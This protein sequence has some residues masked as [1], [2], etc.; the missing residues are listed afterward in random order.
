VS[1]IK[2][3][4]AS[5]L[6]RLRHGARDLPPLA[7]ANLEAADHLAGGRPARGYSY[8]VVD[9]ETTG[10]DTASDR[11]V[12]VGAVRVA[13]GRVRLGD[14][15]VE[16]VNPGRGIPAEA[17]KIHGI[18]PDQV[19]GARDAAAV[20]QDFLAW[21]GADILV[22]HY[23]EFDLH[24]INLTMRRLYGFPLQNLVLDVV[25]MCRGVVLP[26]DPYGLDRHRASCAL[27]SLAQRF[28]LSGAERHT[29]AGDALVTAMIFQRLL[30]RLES[31]G[32]GRLADLARVAAL[33]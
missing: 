17:V 21:L 4:L 24:F 26:S 15:F 14:S 13:G 30:A 25:R 20:F 5:R 31:R 23:A 7:K 12:A 2:R 11:V 19:A 22:A 29:A 33:D 9:L 8:A 1:L 16:L 6:A 28:G 18:K 3:K 32:P 27:E 10:L